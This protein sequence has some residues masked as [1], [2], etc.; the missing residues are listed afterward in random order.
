MKTKCFHCSVNRRFLARIERKCDAI[1]ALLRPRTED[2]DID[3]AID[4]MHE[5]ARRMKAMAIK[6][7]QR[8]REQF[9]PNKQRR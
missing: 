7:A 8:Y 3:R 1:L 6:E 2:R 5:Q 9:S 4:I